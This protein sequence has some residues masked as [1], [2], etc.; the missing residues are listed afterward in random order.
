MK[1]IS[2][3]DFSLLMDKLPIVIEYAKENISPY[4]LKAYNALR[5]LSMLHT[6]LVNQNPIKSNRNDKK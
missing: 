4:D 1:S 6:K 2:N 3:S 5:M